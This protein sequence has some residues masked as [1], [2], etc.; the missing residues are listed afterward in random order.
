MVFPTIT[1]Q[2]LIPIP[3]L[4]VIAFVLCV[5][6]IWTRF[7]ARKLYL[8]DYLIIVAEVGGFNVASVFLDCLMCKSHGTLTQGPTSAR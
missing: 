4:T 6:R 3:P 1:L 8:D 2:Y 5:L 7:R